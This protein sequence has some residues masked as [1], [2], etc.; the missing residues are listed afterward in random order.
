M[1]RSRSDPALVPGSREPPS[2]LRHPGGDRRHRRH[3][4]GPRAAPRVRLPDGDGSSRGLKVARSG[5]SPSTP[6]TWEAPSTP[7]APTRP[8]LVQLCDSF[9]PTAPLFS[10]TR[11]AS[12]SGPRSRLAPRSVTLPASSII[13][14]SLSVPFGT[15]VVRKGY[16]LGTQAM[17]GGSFQARRCSG[18]R[19]D[20]RGRGDGSRGCRPA[21]ILSRA[22]GGHRSGGARPAVRRDGRA[23]LRQTVMRQ[24]GSY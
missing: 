2:G 5:S 15:I 9:R 4:L 22:G 23:G 20:R 3:Q 6:P 18:P 10:A 14:A 1:D 21:G 24:P 12:W 16:G 8:W 13:G 7:T 11:P 17:A 19:A